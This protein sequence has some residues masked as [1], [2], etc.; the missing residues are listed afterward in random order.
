MMTETEIEQLLLEVVRQ[1][2]KT[3]CAITA[4]VQMLLDKGVLKGDEASVFQELESRTKDLQ[5][6]QLAEAWVEKRA[7]DMRAEWKKLPKQ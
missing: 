4:L 7:S 1:N 2:H 3:D 5:K 6:E